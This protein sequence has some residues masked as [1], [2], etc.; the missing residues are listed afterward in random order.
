MSDTTDLFPEVPLGSILDL[1]YGAPL[2]DNARTNHGYPVYG[3]NG[4]IGRHSSYLVNGPGIIVGRKGSV[5]A[6]CWSFESFWPI[7]TTFYVVPKDDN[8][9]RWIYWLLNYVD[10]K[11]LDA[12]TGVPG[13]NRNDAYDV[14]IH[15]TEPH[16]QH[17]IAAVLDT[18]AAAIANAEAVIAKLRQIR[19]GLLHDLLTR[20]IDE[21]GELRDPVEH[22]EQFR[23]TEVGSIPNEWNVLG[24]LDI[25]S[26]DRQAI[27]TGP[28]GAELGHNDFV[29]EGIPLLRIGNVQAGYIDFSDLLFVSQEKALALNRYRVQPGDLLFARQG[30]TT[31]R[32]ALVP[33]SVDGFL[34]NYHIIRVAV[35]RTKC[36]PILLHAIF[37][38]ETVQ[39]QINRD[40]GRGTREGINSHEI[41]SLRFALPRIDEQQ[42]CLTVLNALS[43]DIEHE[44]LSLAKLRSLKAGLM[45]DLLTGRVR[46]PEDCSVEAA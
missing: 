15:A 23:E 6:S 28:F 18:I 46:V 20:G 29:R 14:S 24:I 38:S 17:R 4:I 34:I 43:T 36:E 33:D 37:N 9:Q 30:A 21:N 13:L 31:G 2:P 32:N 39:R 1:E 35:D 3:S 27:L 45:D 22:P 11:K 19:S 10:F 7:D 16:E 25:A 26:N 12:A 42:R 40:K 8:S 44:E 41:A 5:G